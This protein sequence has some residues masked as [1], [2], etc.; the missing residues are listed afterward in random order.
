MFL[1][2][3]VGK[4]KPFFDASGFSTKKGFYGGLTSFQRT[5]HLMLQDF[6]CILKYARIIIIVVQAGANMIVSGS[7]VVKSDDPGGV[8]KKLKTAVESWI[9]QWPTTT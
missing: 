2:I 4:L 8:I 3:K 9:P 7:A 1:E 6:L 5:T